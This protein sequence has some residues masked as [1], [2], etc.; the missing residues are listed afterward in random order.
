[1]GLIIL[2]MPDP[3]A[4]IKEKLKRSHENVINL[5]LEVNR[6]FEEGKYP[7][8]LPEDDVQ[9]LLEA[10]QY[11]MQRE[12]PLRFSVLI[13]ET[14]HHLRSILDHIVWQFSRESFREEHGDWIEFPIRKTRPDDKNS[15]KRFERKI[16]GVTDV[17]V[18]NFI[19]QLQPYNATNPIDSPLLAIHNIDVI[20]KHREL[21]LCVSSGAVELPPDI[22]ERLIAKFSASH[23]SGIPEAIMEAEFRREI[24]NNAKIVPTISFTDFRGRDFEAIVPAMFELNN[25]VVCIVAQF[26]RFLP[27]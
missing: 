24:E 12:V 14:A 18:R 17:R 11:H 7:A 15:I 25:E 3:F 23:Q 20:D 16:E 19:E 4:G 8:L 22:S 26:D 2:P 1:M 21:V 6:F 27:R 13:G 10:A 5:Q 9:A